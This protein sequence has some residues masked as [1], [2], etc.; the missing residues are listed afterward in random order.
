MHKLISIDHSNNVLNDKNEVEHICMSPAQRQ[1]LG[2][3]TLN[4][5]VVAQYA[6]K[7]SHD[8]AQLHLKQILQSWEHALV[9]S[10]PNTQIQ[11]AIRM[12]VHTWVELHIDHQAQ[13]TC[14][15]NKAE[16][17]LRHLNNCLSVFN[18]G[19]NP[20]AIK[21]LHYLLLHPIRNL[22]NYLMQQQ[23]DLQTTVSGYYH[24]LEGSPNY[25]S[26]TGK[27]FIGQE[28]SRLLWRPFN[29]LILGI[30]IG[31]SLMYMLQSTIITTCLP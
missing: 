27:L 26:I 10:V 29:M 17:L 7:L 14:R 30:T 23:A 25:A 22:P 4:L 5:I 31:L 19:D 2:S 9:A 6:V 8:K 20:H 1:N 13:Q 12:A 24:S 15:N 3:A 11:K 28:K 18:L 16:V 21:V